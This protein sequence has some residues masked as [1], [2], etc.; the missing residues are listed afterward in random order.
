VL[1]QGRRWRWSSSS[2]AGQVFVPP[3]IESWD[4]EPQWATGGSTA[5]AAFMMLAVGYLVG[6]NSS[7]ARPRGRSRTRRRAGADAHRRDLHDL[8]GQSLTS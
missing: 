4:A 5:L 6:T 7:C 8:L 3:L 1:P 2:I